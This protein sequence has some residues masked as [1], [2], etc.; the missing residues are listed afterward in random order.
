MRQ[1]PPLIDIPDGA[2][3]RPANGEPWVD[4]IEEQLHARAK[5]VLQM[6]AHAD[7][8]L[9]AVFAHGLDA[10]GEEIVD[11]TSGGTATNR[12]MMEFWRVIAFTAAKHLMEHIDA[13]KEDDDE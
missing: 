5:H 11:V 13:A 3:H 1:L 4:Q 7:G 12:Q 9:W 6:Q 2:R 8:S 10:D